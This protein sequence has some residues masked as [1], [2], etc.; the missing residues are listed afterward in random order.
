MKMTIYSAFAI[1]LEY[2]EATLADSITECATQLAQDFPD[3]QSNL[4]AFEAAI[5]GKSL[6]QLQEAYT[7][8]FDMMP[9][10]TPNLGHHIFGDDARRGVFLAELKARMESRGMTLGVELPDHIGLIL[11]YLDVAEE[12]RPPVIED[13]M[14]PAVSRML[15]VLNDRG[16]PYEHALRAL[17]NLL[18]RQQAIH[19]ASAE[20]VNA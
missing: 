12:E 9:D 17:L 8:A 20:A 15:E 11:H 16:N 3:A 2:P 7:A 19:A 1:I 10:C 14:I 18:R 4:L 5:A 13:C 6:G